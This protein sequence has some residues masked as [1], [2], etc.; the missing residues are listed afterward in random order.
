MSAAMQKI[1]LLVLLALLTSCSNTNTLEHLQSEYDN[2]KYSRYVVDNLKAQPVV[3]KK[4]KT[5]DNKSTVLVKRQ[6]ESRKKQAAGRLNGAINQNGL[7]QPS[8][9][10]LQ[11]IARLST[12]KKLEHWLK[13]H[14]SLDTVLTIALSNNLDILSAKEQA[15]ASLAK[16][17]QVTYLD[18]MLAQY[19]A[20]TKDITLTGSTQ[21]HKKSVSAGFP[22]PGL[23][24]L[25]SS[26][27][28]Q[29]VESSRLVVKQTSQDVITNA[30][31]AYYQLQF[32]QQEISIIIENKKLLK[33]LKEELKGNYI[34]NS[35]EL[36][37]ILQVDIEIANNDNLLL[38]AKD[39]RRATQ[40][41]LNALL[42]ISSSFSLGKLDKFIPTEFT[43]DT[44]KLINKGKEK[45]I[46]VTRLRSD[47]EKM[48]RV[49]QL[50]EKRFYPDFDAG[51]SRFQKGKFTTKPKIK[52]NNFFAKND[53]YL[54]E[55][56]AKVKAL[57]SKIRALQN[58]TA[59]EIQQAISNYQSQ[60][61][62]YDLY[63][64]KVLPKAKTTLTVAKNL[65]ETGE[66]SFIE[67]I[68]EQEMILNYR[69]KA[70]KG[71]EGIN[72][73]KAKLARFIGS[74][75]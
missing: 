7:Y 60:K 54:T 34:T 32:V 5:L 21:K 62:T 43:G 56:R 1:S 31:V 74:V 44:E 14:S 20:F 59:G 47:L 67:I 35:A 55:T 18:D 3:A 17:D 73:N 37:N 33:S 66:A 65:F 19:A 39:R 70:I 10:L 49:I 27:I 45:R 29:T 71:I 41:R 16:Y 13:N 57:Q 9:A 15:K 64:N 23:T 72:I 2:H 8:Q 25:K 51:F 75:L 42:N 30:R 52:K 38:V 24:T 28:D 53:A 69:L 22:F 4:Q 6:L 11:S 40:A 58:R 46:E 61:R 50:S 68:E 48:K 12:Q 63:R 36:S 26:I